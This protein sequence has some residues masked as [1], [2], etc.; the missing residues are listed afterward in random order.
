MTA[1]RCRNDVEHGL[2][3]NEHVIDN[4]FLIP[5]AQHGLS[6]GQRS[7]QVNGKGHRIRINRFFPHPRWI[8][9]SVRPYP[10]GRPWPGPLWAESA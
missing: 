7:R 3:F 5:I 4:P 9:K 8:R 2:L 1:R 10:E 6:A